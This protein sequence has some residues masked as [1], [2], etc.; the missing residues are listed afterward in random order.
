EMS[1]TF[2]RN[3]DPVV[4]SPDGAFVAAP[5]ADGIQIMPVDGTPGRKVPGGAAGAVPIAWCR[6]GSLL[7]QKRS[8]IP[9]KVMRLNLQSGAATPWRDIAPVERAGVRSISS[10]RIGADCE[11]YLYTSVLQ[12]DTLA[13]VTGVK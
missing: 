2:D 5:V 1:T 6:D 7:V 12:A 9:V 13:V 3:A 4:L 10:I 11:T 8:G